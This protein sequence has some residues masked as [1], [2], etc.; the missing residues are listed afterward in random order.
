MTRLFLVPQSLHVFLWVLRLQGAI[1][2]ILLANYRNPIKHFICVKKYFWGSTV[3]IPTL[4]RLGYSLS[5]YLLN[6]ECWWMWVV[7]GR[8]SAGWFDWWLALKLKWYVAMCTHTHTYTRSTY[9]NM[10]KVIY[11][12]F[13][14]CTS[15]R[16]LHGLWFSAEVS[17]RADW[18]GIRYQCLNSERQWD[19]QPHETILFAV[20]V[21]LFWLL[22]ISPSRR[23]FLMTGNSK[24]EESGECEKLL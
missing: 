18:S 20:L 5:E 6:E 22:F 10:S 14:V 12:S 24:Y 2:R 19:N 17:V 7:G 3:S 9:A 13:K 21:K 16:W 11:V 1:S 15:H 4:F 8:H 23:V